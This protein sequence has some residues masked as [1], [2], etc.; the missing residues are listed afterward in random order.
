MQLYASL[1]QDS[2]LLN[3]PQESVVGISS[4]SKIKY[5]REGELKV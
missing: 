5:L 3:K 2:R 4:I 1:I